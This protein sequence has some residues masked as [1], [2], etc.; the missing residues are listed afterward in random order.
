MIWTRPATLARRHPN[1]AVLALFVVLTVLLF[2]DGW[3]DPQGSNIGWY[4]DP[5][6]EMWFLAWT[7]YAIAHHQ[8]PFFTH[9]INYPAGVNL[10]WNTLMF[11][12]GLVLAPFTVWLGPVFAYNMMVTTSV[13]LTGWCGYLAARRFVDSHAAAILAGLIFGF[14][15][16]ISAQSRDHPNLIAA[17]IPPLML[18]VLD[19]TLVR[20][21]RSAWRSGLFLGLLGAAQFYISQE[22]L[23]SEALAI[24]IGIAI[25]A[26]SHPRAVRPRIAHAARSLGLALWVMWILTAGPLML[27]FLGAQRLSG[28]VQPSDWFVN[29]LLNFVLP[30]GALQFSPDSATSITTGFT[31]NISEWNA[32]LGIPLL[33]A[34]VAVVIRCRRNPVVR[35]V[36]VLGFTMAVLSLGSE[37]H[38]HGH[39]TDIPLPWR[40]IADLP[41]FENVLPN[42]L[43]LYTDLMLAVLLAIGAVEL[44][45]WTP[46]RPRLRRWAGGLAVTGAAAVPLLPSV[47]YPHAPISVPAFF[48]DGEAERIPA[49]AVVLVAPMQQMFPDEPMLWQAQAA[50]RYRM[51]QGYFIGPDASGQAMYGAQY[52]YMSVAMEDL[53]YGHAPAVTPV[54]RANILSDMRMRDVST[55]LVGPMARQPEMLQFLT[56][57]L[58][59]PPEADDG[60]YIWWHV[61]P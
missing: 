36:A 49:D 11:L 20:Q 44:F 22:L 15:P 21:Q 27:Q 24:V 28:A 53:Q 3:S 13:A 57:I 60:V 32:Y 14:S 5:P 33:L 23:A 7:P 55:V 47:P 46:A 29:D 2:K 39:H 48:T 9:H 35:F 1:I 43:A 25:L 38:I 10:M 54:L 31:G 26:A 12:P 56:T 37:L 59:T 34:V 50:F 45:G 6:H 8:W 40:A 58:G 41:V 52:S 18:I 19:E 30:T 16:Y 51:P 4:G 61:S 42:R 17:F